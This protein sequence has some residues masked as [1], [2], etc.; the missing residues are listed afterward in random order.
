[1]PKRIH[2]QLKNNTQQQMKLAGISIVYPKVMIAL[3]TLKNQSAKK[4]LKLYLKY[5]I[6]PVMKY[7][8]L[9]LSNVYHSLMAKL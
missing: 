7:P 2:I 6:S 9:N 5:L 4:M 3:I 1:M 8:H